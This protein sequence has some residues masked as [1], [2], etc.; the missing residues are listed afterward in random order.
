[1]CSSGVCE[2]GCP[3]E[4]SNECP[5]VLGMLAW[6]AVPM[7][8]TVDTVWEEIQAAMI[9]EDKMVEAVNNGWTWFSLMMWQY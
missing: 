1:M 6:L 7:Q 8:D 5:V 4:V 2:G 3:T 9:K